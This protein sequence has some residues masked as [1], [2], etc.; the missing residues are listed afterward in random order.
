MN[1]NQQTN[2]IFLV[3]LGTSNGWKAKVNIEVEKLK[4]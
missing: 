4:W 1:K 3:F 2:E